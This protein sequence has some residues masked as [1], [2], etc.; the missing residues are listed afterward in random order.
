M[1]SIPKLPK[2]FNNHELKLINLIKEVFPGSESLLQTEYRFDVPYT[3]DIK[4]RKWRF[5]IAFPHVKIAFEVEGGTW[6]GGRHIN[7]I[8]YAKDCE[9]YNAATRQGWKVYRLTPGMISQ[10]YI[11]SLFMIV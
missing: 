6:V 5:D 10:D 11:E 7:P 3:K 1:K 9:K 2:Q 4:Q 8:G